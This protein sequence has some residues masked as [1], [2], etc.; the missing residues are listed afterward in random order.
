MDEDKKN[1]KE[2]N[3]HKIFDIID[4]MDLVE[5]DFHTLQNVKNELASKL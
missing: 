4:N 1:V 5:N 2:I 3:L